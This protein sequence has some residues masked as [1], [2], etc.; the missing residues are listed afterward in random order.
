LSWTYL[1]A[2]GATLIAL[3]LLVGLSLNTKATTFI[4]DVFAELK[5]VTWPT[6]KETTQSTIAVSV[7][8]G[9]AAVLLALLDWLW[10]VIF[11]ILL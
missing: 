11:K 7:M 1:A 3:M 8:V 5:K 10:G 2:I 4:D 6:A 9:L